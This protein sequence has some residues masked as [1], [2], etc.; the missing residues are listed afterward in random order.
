M[1]VTDNQEVHEGDILV[2]IDPRDSLDA[3]LAAAEADADAAT[4]QFIAADARGALTEVNVA[5]SCVQARGGLTQASAS[6]CATPLGA[7]AGARRRAGRRGRATSWRSR[8]LA[9]ARELTSQKAVPQAELN[10]ASPAPTRPVRSWSRRAP[11]RLHRSEPDRFDRGRGCNRAPVAAAAQPAHQQIGAAKAAVAQAELASTRRRA[12]RA[13]PLEPQLRRRARAARPAWSRGARSRRGRWSS[14][15]TALALVP[16]DDIW[17]VAN[18]KEDQIA[19]MQPG[20]ARE[21]DVDTFGGPQLRGHV[22]S[23]AGAS[24]A[25]FALLP[26]DNASGNFV[27]VVQRV[28]VLVRFDGDPRRP[29]CARA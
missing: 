16:L 2:E 14:G 22:D 18:F 9:R 23:L 11:T 17:V 28:P 26:P 21:V 5:A 13:R 15:A 4:A 10:P 12:A 8:D 25:R 1:L 29:S 3:R 19:E 20:P 6:A 27:K 24:G 7:R